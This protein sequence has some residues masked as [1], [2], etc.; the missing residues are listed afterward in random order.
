MN[1]TREEKKTEAIERMKAWG[2]FD[3][4]IDQFE[5][6]DLISQSLPPVG[7]CYWI[8]GEQLQRV[9]DFENENNALVYFVIHSYT[10]I[11][12]LESYLFVSDYKEDWPIDREDIKEGQQI[13]YVYNADDP[14]CSEMGSIGIEL[15][16][17]AGLRRT[18]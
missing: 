5:K 12:E 8:E 7:A 14:W 18:W 10:N 15:T 6:E 9:K 13:V 4:T 11:G 16:P 1:V 2:I 3:Q 17:A